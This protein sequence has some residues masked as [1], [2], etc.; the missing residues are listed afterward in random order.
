VEWSGNGICLSGACDICKKDLSMQATLNTMQADSLD[1]PEAMLSD[2]MHSTTSS[3]TTVQTIKSFVMWFFTITTMSGV[4]WLAYQVATHNYY[5]PGDDI[6]YNLGLAGGLMMLTLLIYPL[7][8]RFAFMRRIGEMRYWFGL[9]MM[10][11]I[12]GP[13]LIIFHSN[14]QIHSVNAGVALFSMAIVAVSGFI[15]RY[16][17]RH[18]HRGL[19]GSRLTL[20]E[21]REELLGAKDEADSK[22]KNYPGVIFVLHHFQRYA[23]KPNMSLSAKV[24][25]F[26]SLPF[27]RQIANYR[28]IRIVPNKSR[29]GRQV[30]QMILDYLYSVERAAQ[31][32]AFERIFALWHVVHIPLVYM[33]VATAIW[34]VVAVHMY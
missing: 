9:H 23:L 27:R 16:A 25:R 12:F 19:Y 33:L 14:F 30:R 26:F 21:I 31:F 4:A 10:L 13:L 34:H 32:T 8:K 1:R 24:W 7:R 15:G 11:G 20:K 5:R 2:L 6:G 29:E 22:L 3:Q 18:I 17:Y 28:C